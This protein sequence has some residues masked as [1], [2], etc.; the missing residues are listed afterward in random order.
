MTEPSPTTSLRSL[1]RNNEEPVLALAPMDGLSHSPFRLLVARYGR[2][3][4]FWTE[5][6]AAGAVTGAKNDPYLFFTPEERPIV[7]QL[8]GRDPEAFERATAALEEKDFFGYDINF[9][10]FRGRAKRK[11]WGATLLKEPERA[12]ELVRAV[13]RV[14][15]RPIFVK[16][17]SPPGHDA[18]DLFRFVEGVLEA[19][20]DVLVFHPRA[21]EDGFK[22]PARWEEIAL[23]KERFGALVIGNGDVFSPEDAERMLKET[24]CDGVMVGRAVL[25]RPWFF[26]DAKAFFRKEPLPEP[27]HPFEPVELMKNLVEVLPEGL[28]EKRFDLWLFW[29][30]QNFPFAL[31]Y[32]GRVKERRSVEEKVCVLEELLRNERFRPYPVRP[33]IYR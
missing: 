7:V 13:R 16:F 25:L 15:E 23:V 4:L 22:R 27:P 8:A 18:E 33:I 14:T 20:A 2:P 5:M 28:R 3:H 26:R 30:L 11:G 32:F 17:R 31:H 29:Y 10:C 1:F 9:G 12:F 24:G 19:G 21:P 6:V